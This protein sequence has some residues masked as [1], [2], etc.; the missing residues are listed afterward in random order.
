MSGLD[1][2]SNPILACVWPDG[3]IEPLMPGKRP[4]HGQARWESRGTAQ[5]AE[6][7]TG[8][9]IWRWHSEILDLRPEFRETDGSGASLGAVP[10]NRSGM[11]GAG[12]TMR[13]LLWTHDAVDLVEIGGLAATY[14]EAAND[15][16]PAHQTNQ[17]VA[18][19]QD[20]SMFAVSQ[21]TDITDMVREGGRT[22]NVDGLAYRGASLLYFTPPGEG[23]RFW[24]V[25]IELT[26]NKPARVNFDPGS[27]GINWQA[28]VY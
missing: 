9:W 8:G 28:S 2:R 27:L 13:I 26:V 5:W 14:F 25:W 23:I 16:P 4:D 3:T 1:D 15:Q 12:A 6:A 10:V 22:R 11:M 20:A 17:A 24:Q 18:G 7:E 19:L 21:P